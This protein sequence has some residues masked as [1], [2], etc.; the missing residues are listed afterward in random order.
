LLLDRSLYEKPG[1][2][3]AKWVMSPPL[4]TK[5]DQEALWAA[6]RDGYI[7]TIATDHCPFNF[8]GQKDLGKDSFAKIPNGAPGIE[9]RMNL[10]HTYGVL[11]GR[12]SLNRFVQITSTNPAK[13]FGMYPK[14]GTIAPG[15]DADLVLFDPTQEATISAQTSRHR[16]DYSAFEGTK[17][18]G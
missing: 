15:S 1:F 7:Q 5:S 9:N 6:L 18:N 3:G 14:K 17:E 16:C 8:L 10:M 11:P 12:I 2:E 4:R 13:I